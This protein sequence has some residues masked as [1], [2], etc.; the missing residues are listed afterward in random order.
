MAA[1]AAARGAE[2]ANTTA[3]VTKAIAYE[4]GTWETDGGCIIQVSLLERHW[5]LLCCISCQNSSIPVIGLTAVQLGRGG[6]QQHS[7]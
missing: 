4:L 5:C 1:A 6:R 7:K 2:A 3:A